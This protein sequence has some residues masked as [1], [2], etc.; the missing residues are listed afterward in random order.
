MSMLTDSEQWEALRRELESVAQ[1]AKAFNAYVFDAWDKQWCAARGFS[2]APRDDLVNIVHTAIGGS[3]P[4]RRGGALDTVV[5]GRAGHAYLKSF[6]SC[7][8]LLLRYAGGFDDHLTRAVVMDQIARIEA[9]TMALPPPDG[10]GFDAAD[11]AK[12][13]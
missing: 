1:R 5:S 6:G 4:L 12:R 3:T 11:A 9:L 7:Y 10:P 13:A 2:D 8:I